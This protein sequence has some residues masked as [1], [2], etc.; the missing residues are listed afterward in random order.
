[1]GVAAPIFYFGASVDFLLSAF[2][3]LRFL[4]DRDNYWKMMQ[5]YIGADITSLVT[6]PV[7]ICEPMTNLQKM[8]EVCFQ[9]IAGLQRPAVFLF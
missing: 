8:A 1:M 4:Q 6:L 5:K 3:L 7:I 9:L 2:T